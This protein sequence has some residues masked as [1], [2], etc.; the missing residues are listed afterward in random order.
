M[1]IDAEGDSFHPFTPALKIF[2][3]QNDLRDLPCELFKLE[4][5]NVLSLRNNKL[6]ELPPIV[7]HLHELVEMNIAYNRLRFLPYELL[8]LFSDAGRLHHFTMHPNPFYEPEE[9]TSNANNPTAEESISVGL[10][11][12]F[13]P[14]SADY[15]VRSQ[16]KP[17]R[18]EWNLQYHYRSPVRY[19]SI[20]GRL[21][22]GPEF[23]HEQSRDT[24][25]S[26]NLTKIP[27]SSPDDIPTPPLG[28]SSPE[29]RVPSLVELVLRE[30]S[31]QPELPR[32][33]EWCAEDY[34]ERLVPL[35]KL[36]NKV[37]DAGGR[38]CTVCKQQFIL[39]RTEWIEWWEIEKIPEK[40]GLGS[41][42]SPLRHIENRREALVPLMRR[43]CSWSC[44]PT[45]LSD[46]GTEEASQ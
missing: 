31:R 37:R 3:S 28:K 9:P 42:A 17:W 30:C 6:H 24:N 2:L 23:P 44:G 36:A 22:K 11:R 20:D 46:E 16:Q 43:G 4:N 39:P 14:R 21:L 32:M 7:N 25:N 34:P 35:L 12:K 45:K 18:P 8:D 26:S 41:A 13:K 27:I 19:F 15:N 33:I 29:S 1:P 5:L 38:S 10:G 40:G